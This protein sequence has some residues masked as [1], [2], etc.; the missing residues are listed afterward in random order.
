MS[1]WY[2]HNNNQHCHTKQLFE[3]LTKCHTETSRNYNLTVYEIECLMT[4]HEACQMTTEKP[5]IWQLKQP[6]L[7]DRKKWTKNVPQQHSDWLS[8]R[9]GPIIPYQL[10]NQQVPTSVYALCKAALQVQ[11]HIQ[12]TLSMTIYCNACIVEMDQWYTT[13]T[14]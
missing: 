12:I 1:H 14:W 2:H 11:K 4:I 7:M 8:L 9:N 10:K 6:H 5:I 3:K 13:H